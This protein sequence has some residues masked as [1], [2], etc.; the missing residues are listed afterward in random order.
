MNATSYARLAGVIFAIVAVLQLARAA[1]GWPVT[2][3]GT[4]IPVSASWVAGIVAGVLAL[5]G[6]TSR[7]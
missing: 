2:V 6:F 7:A 5:L 3:G 4:G 1:A